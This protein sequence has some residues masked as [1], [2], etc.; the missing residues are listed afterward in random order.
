MKTEMK[1]NDVSLIYRIKPFSWRN[2]FD[3]STSI[4]I[5]SL[6]YMRQ[7]ARWLGVGAMIGYQ[8]F[9]K[10]MSLIRVATILQQRRCYV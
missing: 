4:G 10:K 6:Q 1:N 5:F 7:T 2:I 3:N 8:H 9:G